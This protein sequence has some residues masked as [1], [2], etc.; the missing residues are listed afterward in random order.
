MN[1]MIFFL[2][3]LYFD[4]ALPELILVLVLPLVTGSLLRQSCYCTNYTSLDSL[5]HWRS[6]CMAALRIRKLILVQESQGAT[7]DSHARFLLARVMSL[8]WRCADVLDE[9]DVAAHH[10]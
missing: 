6:T 4:H 10:E 5:F 8:E 7:A 1:S 9:S 3:M 2:T